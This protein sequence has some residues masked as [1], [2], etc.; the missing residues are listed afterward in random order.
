M[1]SV[2]NN[3]GSSGFYCN[4]TEDLGKSSKPQKLEMYLRE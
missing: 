1:G 3:K 2:S 4:M